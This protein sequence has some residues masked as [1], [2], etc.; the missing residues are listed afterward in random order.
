[1]HHKADH[2]HSSL[3]DYTCKNDPL[4]ITLSDAQKRSGLSC[5]TLYHANSQG[6]LTMCKAGRRTLVDAASLK[7]FLANL[8]RF[9]S[10]IEQGGAR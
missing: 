10:G 2:E 8:P 1:M 7:D 4:T 3:T 5:N 6:N 9:V